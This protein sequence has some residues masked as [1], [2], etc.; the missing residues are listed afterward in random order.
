MQIGSYYDNEVNQQ[1]TWIKLFLLS[2]HIQ[3]FWILTGD[4]LKLL[5]VMVSLSNPVARR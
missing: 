3:N 2:F 4:Q 5:T 1:N